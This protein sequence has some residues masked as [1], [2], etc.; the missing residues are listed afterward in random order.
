MRMPHRK[1][2]QRERLLLYLRK[3]SVKI[4]EEGKI[5]AGREI[6]QKGI[7]EALGTGRNN[8]PRVIKPL[9][10]EGYVKVYKARVSGFKKSEMFMYSWK[11]DR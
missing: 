7:A 9:I 8:I 5:Y 10:E 2:T 11:R 3:R 4:S 6:T 1:L